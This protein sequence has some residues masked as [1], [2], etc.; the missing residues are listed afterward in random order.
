MTKDSPGAYSTPV[1]LTSIILD[2]EVQFIAGM[3]NKLNK[4][5]EIQTK[6]LT[7]YHPQTDREIEKIN[8]ELKQYLRVFIDHRQKQW[9]DW[10]GTAEFAYNNKIYLVTKISPF[11]ANYS[12]DLRMGF[13]RRRRGEF[14]TAGRFVE[15]MKKIQ[16]KAKAVLGK[17]Q[18]EI[19]RYANRK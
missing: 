18:E 16:E 14:K 5:L 2:R 17:V 8:Q 7:A 4:L 10:L 12:Q 6:L 13:E 1:A 15:R 19:K 11:K 3:M 9:L